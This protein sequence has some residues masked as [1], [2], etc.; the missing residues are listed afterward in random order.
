M[1]F[2]EFLIT[3]LLTLTLVTGCT[4]KS[5]TID[6]SNDDAIVP[7]S[8][9]DILVVCTHKYTADLQYRYLLRRARQIPQDN[10]RFIIL[11]TDVD[12]TRHMLTSE[13]VVNYNC[14]E[15]GELR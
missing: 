6:H 11:F 5:D 9:P 7:S 2:K 3:V 1:R 13:E 10:G 4:T 15:Y 8:L 14:D 12:G